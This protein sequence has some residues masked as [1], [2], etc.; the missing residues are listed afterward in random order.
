MVEE[1]KERQCVVTSYGG[2]YYDG[3]VGYHSDFLDAKIFNE[4]EIPDYI[5]NN[6]DDKII[7]LDTKEG[8]E[9]LV[10]EFKKLQH[11]TSIYESRVEDA[12]EGM[13]KL[14]GFDSIK[15]YIEMRNKRN[16]PL[17]GISRQTEKK[18]IEKIVGGRI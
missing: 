7:F 6:R 17:I 13:K 11:Y 18:I 12:K 10:T 15:K 5:R 3:N 4:N 9:L 8:L 14:L 16:N 1:K 2:N